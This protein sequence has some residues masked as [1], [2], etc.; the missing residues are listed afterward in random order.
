MRA[1]GLIANKIALYE[2]PL[3]DMNLNCAT[4]KSKYFSRETDILLLVLTHKYG[5]GNW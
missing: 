1:P 4:Q 5:Y 3:E 2:N